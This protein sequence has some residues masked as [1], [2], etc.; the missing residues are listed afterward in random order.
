VPVSPSEALVPVRELLAVLGIRPG[1]L[2]ALVEHAVGRAGCQ[3]GGGP[4]ERNRGSGRSYG[5][6]QKTNCL[7]SAVF[8]R[9][10]G[11]SASAMMTPQRDVS[12]TH[13]LRQPAACP[14]S[15]L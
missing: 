6:T 7:I 1:D 5:P 12:S 14:A 13:S 3:P 4:Q 9:A 8:S 2:R 15:R 10:C 11:Q